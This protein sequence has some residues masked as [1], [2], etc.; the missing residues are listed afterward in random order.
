MDQADN[1]WSVNYRKIT[2]RLKDGTIITGKLN[3]AEYPKMSDYFNISPHNFFAL[4]DVEYDG[5]SNKSVIIINK[6]E[7]AWT[8]M[9]TPGVKW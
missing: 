2:V 7:V 8:E 3:T 1:R 9:K 6:D 4:I 5:S